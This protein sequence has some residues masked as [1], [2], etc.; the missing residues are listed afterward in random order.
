LLNLFAEY[1]AL[2]SLVY[3]ISRLLSLKVGSAAE[4]LS[5]LKDIFD[6]PCPDQYNCAEALISLFQQPAKIGSDD[7]LSNTLDILA[8]CNIFL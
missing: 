5:L 8:K 3:L 1:L 2:E 6:T 4:K 7:L